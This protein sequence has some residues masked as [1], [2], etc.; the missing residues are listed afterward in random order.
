MPKI[1]GK[2]KNGVW[3]PTGGGDR[4]TI[5]GL[6][7]E[8]ALA[9]DDTVPF[10]DTSAKAQRK[11]LWSNI[12][13]VL[14]TYFDG[15]YLKLSGG[16]LSGKIVLPTGN[17]NVGF[18]NSE[19]QKIFGYGPIDSVSHMRIGDAGKPLQLRGSGN[20]PKYNN[21]T[22]VLKTEFEAALGSYIAD[23]DALIGGDA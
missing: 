4:W 22:L 19:D 18:T 1:Y 14:K 11:T 5:D 10:Y 8:T 20:H 23:I 3:A 15:V 2:D 9:D 17:Q 21:D 16:T 7:E 13:A 12:K 6:T